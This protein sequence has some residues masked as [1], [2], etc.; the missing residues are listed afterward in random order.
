MLKCLSHPPIVRLLVVSTLA[1]VARAQ[2]T[3]TFDSV[4]TSTCTDGTAYMAAAGITVTGQASARICLGAVPGTGGAVALSP[5]NIL[6]L[7]NPPPTN[8]TYEYFFNFTSPVSNV[9]F[10]RTQIQP[11]ST[12]PAW[13]AKALAADGSIISSTGEGTTYAP[14]AQLFQL[15]GNGIVKIQFDTDNTSA[16]T[17][18]TPPIDNFSFTPSLVIT[19]T[20]LPV[21][22]AGQAYSKTLT[23]AGGLAPITWTASG[24]PANLSINS[25][26]TISG[27]PS[28]AGTY[29]VIATATD[30][31][32]G[33]S[34]QMAQVVFNLVVNSDL[35]ITTISLP[36]G[37]QSQR[38]TATLTATGGVTPYAWSQTGL[39]S[40][41]SINSSTGVISG[42]PTA[43]GTFQVA[44]TVI[45]SGAMAQQTQHATFTLNIGSNLT[46]TTAGLPQ[47]RQQLAYS[48]TVAAGGGTPPY[49]WSAASLPT[50]LSIN[51]SNGT[52]TGTPTA[53][54]IFNAVVTVSDSYGTRVQATLPIQIIALLTITNVAVPSGQ[55]GQP[56][57][58]SL[59]ADGGVPPYNWTQTGLPGGLTLSS[60]G[61]ISGAPLTSGNFPVVFKVTDSSP[62]F[63]QSAQTNTINV[64]IAPPPPPPL[65]ITTSS[66][67]NGTAGQIYVAQVAASGG[68]GSYAFSLASGSLPAGIALATSG[69]F[70]GTPTSPGN[71]SF[72]VQVTDGN[73]NS[74]T[75]NYTIQIAP[76]TLAVTGAAPATVDVNSPISIRFGATGGVPPYKFILSGS[77]PG[78]ASLSSDGLLS[79][80]ATAPGTFNFTISVTDTET[81]AA[82]ASASFSIT[83]T[84][85]PISIT[86]S[87]P[88]GTVGLSYSG[89]LSATGGTGGYSWT[90]AA[91]DGLSIGS[92]GAVSGTPTTAGAVVVTATVTDSSGTK[93]TANFTITISGPTLTVT[94]TTL[95]NGALTSAYSGRVS[96]TGG[97]PPYT[98]SAGGLPAGLSLD[99][100]SGN[101]TGTPTELGTFTVNFTVTDSNKVAAGANIDLTINAAPLKITTTDI[102]PAQLGQSF[103]AD[104]GA[105]GG[106]T[107]YTWTATGLPSGVTFSSAGI[108]GGTPSALGMFPI[109]VTV[110]DVN[111]VMVSEPL[112]LVVTLP[113]A[114]GLTYSGLPTT[115]I[116]STQLTSTVTFSG[117]YPVD[118]A[119]TLTLTFT[120][121]NGPDDPNI[122][123]ATGGRTT[124]VTVKGG[125]TVSLSN[126]SIQTGTVAG[127]ILITAQ[128]TA[129][130]NNI[131]PL[132]APTRTILIPPA[133]PTLTSVTAASDGNA[134]TVTLVG[135]DPTRTIT[136]LTFSFTAAAGS[137]LQTSIFTIPVTSLFN[138]WYQSEQAAQYGSQFSFTIPFTVSGSVSGLASVSVMATNPTGI[139]NSVTAVL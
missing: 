112:N 114:P 130:E 64:S 63:P 106:T 27:T 23:S 125:T 2:T 9:S 22:V 79:G 135:F 85:A 47:G 113:I 33:E 41:L 104:F 51:T 20:S 122:Q 4:V 59:Q 52:I 60:N 76:G 13:T 7:D 100:N 120:P 74:A 108:L 123:F 88:S 134:F 29:Q 102:P 37:A 115:A 50:G 110:S 10:Y 92:N 126:I 83:V 138:A 18:N 99:P 8:S 96:A 107:P 53:A 17:Y 71:Y 48:A 97:T 70:Y 26:G 72:T 67:A 121:L 78:G 69:Q 56:Y 25:A 86:A 54:G 3:L 11:E 81:P 46:I 128:L 91:G 87:L 35:A 98:W 66:L 16:R 15:P 38:Y 127:T 89:Q 95:P 133:A 118:V 124:T 61:A 90:G 31:G 19:T 68:V 82:H 80:T 109:V 34:Q 43:S 119:V 57:T 116:S 117:T 6:L 5:P 30:S 84:A 93:A 73:N 55:V 131:T 65:Q 32:I 132:P 28:A 12:G 111:K 62:Q 14:A 36:P 101:I 103:T 21:G 40:G 1:V 137:T 39:P 77:A 24:L 42:A 94:T 49:T 44:V 45:D 129:S 136:Q 139:S 58:G 75:H 105:T